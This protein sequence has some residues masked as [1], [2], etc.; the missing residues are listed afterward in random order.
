MKI[1][2]IILIPC[3][4]DGYAITTAADVFHAED[5]VSGFA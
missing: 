4:I 2:G 5:S 3:K 1:D